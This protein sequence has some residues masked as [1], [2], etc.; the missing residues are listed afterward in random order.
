MLERS[1]PSISPD[2]NSPNLGHAR[3]VRKKI[4]P[5][6]KK[7]LNDSRKDKDN[8]PREDP[9]VQLAARWHFSGLIKAGG[10]T[11]H[12]TR[13]GL[14]K[15]LISKNHATEIIT[16]SF[17]RSG[18][19]TRLDKTRVT[20]SFSTF[21]RH[22]SNRTK[23]GRKGNA[24]GRERERDRDGFERARQRWA[25]AQVRHVHGSRGTVRRNTTCRVGVAWLSTPSYPRLL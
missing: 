24:W 8:W 13:R 18:R 7:R 9:L 20:F 14:I 11:R 6:L 3:A 25:D 22:V 21:T 10:T 4:L 1:R 23:E 15:R 12:V 5:P 19:R 2:N 16:S 17:A